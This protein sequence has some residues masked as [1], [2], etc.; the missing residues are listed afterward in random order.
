VAVVL[1]GP[2]ANQLHLTQGS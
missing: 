2:F 1:S